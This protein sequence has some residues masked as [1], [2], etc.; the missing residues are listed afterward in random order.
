[1]PPKKDAKKEPEK[2]FGPFFFSHPDPFV[3]IVLMILTL[4]FLVYITNALVQMIYRLGFSPY[5]LWQWFESLLF[6]NSFWAWF[7]RIILTL[8]SIIIIWLIVDTN[9][10]LTKVREKEKEL[11]YP[12]IT[13][14]N[15]S[16]N[17]AWEKVLKRTESMNEDDWK[18][19]IIEADIMLADLLDKLHL[20]GESIGEKLKAVDKSDFRTLDNAW[21]AHKVRNEIAHGGSS[22]VLTRH[23]MMEVI[24][25]YKSV[26]EE[27]KII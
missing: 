7:I 2:T 6:S 20:L 1:M 27:F 23:R 17:D 21:E 18:L 15:T 24:N 25:L 12:V 16:T 11:L 19:A 8:L 3:E 13:Q 22:F 9:K 14:V 10:K 4:F 26:F 5:S